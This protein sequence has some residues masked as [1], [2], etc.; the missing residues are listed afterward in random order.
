MLASGAARR[1]ASAS[2]WSIALKGSIASPADRLPERPVVSVVMPA[3]NA[4]RS[5][6]RALESALRDPSLAVECVVVD[7]GSTDDTAAVVERLGAAD[8][9]VVFLRSPANEGV[10][11][12][13]NRALRAARGEWVTLLDADDRFVRG[14][15]A[16]LLR[17]TAGGDVL[18][19]VGQ[20]V[21]SDGKRSWISA[22]YDRPDI[23]R[24]GRASL[25]DRPGLVYYATGTGKLFHR[26]LVDGLSFSGRILGDQPWPIR[27]L[28]RAGDRIEVID[29]VVYAWLRPADDAASTITASKRASARIAAEAVRVAV[30][31]F[32]EVA[33][34]AGR[35]EEPSGR[36]R[37]VGTYFERLLSSDFGG[38]VVR[39]V[40]RGDEGGDELFDAIR[41]FL[42]AAPPELVDRSTALAEA[43]LRPPLDRWPQLSEPARSAFWRLLST[44]IRAHPSLVPRISRASLLRLGL[45]VARRSDSA[46]ARRL[47]SAS[48]TLNWPL[49]LI[50]RWRRRGR[51]A[52]RPVPAPDLS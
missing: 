13:R 36:A 5:I 34:E 42:D 14:G 24:P 41:A 18:A 52:N 20:R 22:A 30:G 47:A 12:A 17:P 50:H 8:P 28:I 3:W 2:E 32:A 26:S 29:D 10:S 40:K 46:T 51:L 23:R 6:E 43:V 33:A 1:D 39:A 9:R 4:G 48:F 44:T 7:D 45:E 35:I 31:A 19:V 25:V 21:W 38:P 16:A 37:V 11:A 27:A 49:G 15:L